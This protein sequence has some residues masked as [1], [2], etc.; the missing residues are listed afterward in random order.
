MECEFLKATSL[1]RGHASPQ[2][3]AFFASGVLALLGLFLRVMSTGLLGCVIWLGMLISYSSGLFFCLFFPDVFE[4]R[5]DRFVVAAR[6]FGFGMALL[7]E[8][9]MH[10]VQS[11]QAA[12]VWLLLN[13]P[14]FFTL[15]AN[16]VCPLKTKQFL[17]VVFASLVLLLA[18][19]S[20]RVDDNHDSQMG[21]ILLGRVFDTALEL[22]LFGGV[23]ASNGNQLVCRGV[24]LFSI[25]TFGILLPAGYGYCKELI[26]RT[27]FLRNTMGSEHH[28]DIRMLR[29]NCLEG[30]IWLLIFVLQVA[31]IVM[32]SDY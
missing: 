6:V 30:I 8:E 5:R 17:P 32:R 18:A 22:S 14:V 31:W 12:V 10:Q 7:V 1:R 23:K 9:P 15:V 11:V 24:K 28:Q 21:F 19:P 20:A 13:S 2:E 16:C 4:E 3:V 27:A 26:G 29:K 25:L